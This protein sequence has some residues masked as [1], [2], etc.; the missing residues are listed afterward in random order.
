MLVPVIAIFTK[1]DVLAENAYSDL[2]QEGLTTAAAYRGAAARCDQLLQAHFV[3]P[4]MDM[5]YPPIAYF[6]LKN[7]HKPGGQCV[8]LIQGTLK[9]L[10]GGRNLRRMSVLASKLESKVESRAP[11]E[12]RKA[13]D[14][15][16]PNWVSLHLSTSDVHDIVIQDPTRPVGRG[17][18]G[19]LFLG[20]HVPTGQ[21]LAMKRPTP[22]AHT[23]P[24]VAVR[25]LAREA[26]TWSGFENDNILP[27]YGLVEISNE[28]YLISPWMEYGDLSAFIKKRLSFLDSDTNHRNDNSRTR[29]YTGFRESDVIHGIAS[30]LA[31]LHIRK[32]VHGDLKAL[33]V[34][35]TGELMPL[36]CDFGLTK[37]EDNYNATSTAMKGAGSWRWMSPEVMDGVPKTIESDIYAFGMTIV[38]ILTGSVPCPSLPDLKFVTA[39]LNGTRPVCEPLH[40]LGQDFTTLWRVASACWVSDPSERPTAY[41]IVDSIEGNLPLILPASE[42]Q[43]PWE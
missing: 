10:E 6:P 18:F 9:T 23:A 4:I 1:V 14:I 37:M 33:N 31:Y 35:L 27:F 11:T 15:I 38:E 43:S 34:L 41:R 25:R 12:H 21:M 17:G 3:K 26:N 39:I 16:K 40:R 29:A 20:E 8:G 32:V 30:G 36:I 22:H 5:A 24:E 42:G 2:R 7:L 19:D 13:D 28:V